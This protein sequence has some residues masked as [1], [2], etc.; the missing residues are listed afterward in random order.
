MRRIPA[1]FG[2]RLTALEA[3][4]AELTRDVDRVELKLTLLLERVARLDGWEHALPTGTV[5]GPRTVLARREDAGPAEADVWCPTAGTQPV[6]GRAMAA[7]S[8][9]DPVRGPRTVKAVTS[10]GSTGRAGKPEC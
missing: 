8:A 2:E 10:R 1:A 3:R 7:A 6:R 9:G 4:V 5:T